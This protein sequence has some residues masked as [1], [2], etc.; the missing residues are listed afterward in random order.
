MN[1]VPNPVDKEFNDLIIDMKK[2]LYKLETARQPYFGDWYDFS[3]PV[4]YVSANTLKFTNPAINPATFLQLGDKVK[5]TQTTVKYAY[6]HAIQNVVGGTFKVNSG[7]DY[8]LAASNPSTFSRG[9][10]PT[11][12]G[13]PVLFAFD[14]LILALS[15]SYTNLSP[16][17]FENAKFLMIG[18]L[19]KLKIDVTFGSMSGGPGVLRA[20]PPIESDFTTYERQIM[21]CT[22][23]GGFAIGLAKMGG[24][25]LIEIYANATTLAGFPN[26]T[27]DLGF[28]ISLEFTV[29]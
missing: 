18:R 3:E 14:P 17:N 16:A 15:G 4:Q 6:V 26:T 2:R 23:S 21:S 27:N 28:N 10:V 12:S 11:P 7:K 1:D 13:H 25:N 22:Y 9:L 20:T 29:N 24:A 8:T 19:L 5:Y